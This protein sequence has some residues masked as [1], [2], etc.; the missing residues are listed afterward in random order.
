MYNTSCDSKPK[1]FSNSEK[2]K[3]DVENSLHE[4]FTSSRVWPN[5]TETSE[6]LHLDCR[7]CFLESDSVLLGDAAHNDVNCCI[8]CAFFNSS[9]T[10]EH[11]RTNADTSLLRT[12][13][14]LQ[15]DLKNTDTNKESTV[16]DKI[17]LIVQL[18]AQR[19]DLRIYII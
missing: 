13:N 10:N 15:F 12:T 9:G 19:N 2:L 5:S 8:N 3:K 14:V 7:H 1:K 18:F 4:H 6:S 17:M 11:D 16:L